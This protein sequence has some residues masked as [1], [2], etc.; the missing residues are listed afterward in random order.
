MLANRKGPDARADAPTLLAAV[1]VFSDAVQRLGKG[2]EVAQ[3]LRLA[4]GAF[5]I[6]ARLGKVLSCT[7][8]QSDA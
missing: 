2:G 5:C 3:P 7:A 8:G 6:D 1:R 4:P